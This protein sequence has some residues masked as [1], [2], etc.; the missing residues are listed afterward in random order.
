MAFV[1]ASEDLPVYIQSEYKK[2]KNFGYLM[3]F[4]LTPE[5]SPEYMFY[6]CKFNLWARLLENRVGAHDY[7]LSWSDVGVIGY[8]TLTGDIEHTPEDIIRS[9]GKVSIHTIAQQEGLISAAK[10]QEV[11]IEQKRYDVADLVDRYMMLTGQGG[12]FHQNGLGLLAEVYRISAGNLAKPEVLQIL[13]EYEFKKDILLQE[14]LEYLSKHLNEVFALIVSSNDIIFHPSYGFVQPQEVTDF[15]CKIASFPENV[16]VY[17]PFAGADSYA[18]ALPN[19]VVGEEIN[20]TTWALGQI[21]LFAN[22]ADKRAVITLG[23]S[24]ESIRSNEKFKAI[25]TSPVY[26]M[27]DGHEISDI[28]RMLY[29]K[30]EYGGKLVCIVSANFLFRKDN[31]VRAVRESLIRDKAISAIVML[32]SNIFSGSSIAQAAIV[33]TKGIENKEIHFGDASGH[34][35]FAKSVYRATTFD[36][37]SFMDAFEADIEDTQEGFEPCEDQTGIAVPYEKL[38]GS[39]LTPS[40]YLAPKPE[41]GIPLS[42]LVEKLPE[43]RCKD[44][45]VEYFLTGSSIP[46]AMHRK[47]FVP[48]KAENEKFSTV[49]KYVQVPENAVILAI[50]SGNVRTV[51]TE[52]FT[53][54]IA[55]PDGFINV[56]KPIN[57]ISA[58]YLAAILSTRI[59]ADQIKAQTVGLT[60]PY[61]N[62]LD[63]SQVLVPVHDT[64]EEREK[65]IAEVLS[66]EMSD[67]EGELQEMIDSQKREVRSTRHA[68]VQT[69]SSLS[70]NWEQLKLFANKKGGKIS[71]TDTIG[72]VNPISVE[73][74]LTS[75]GYAIS[76]LERQ[77][78]SLRFERADWGEDVEINP[79][80]FI[81]EYISTH[82]TPNVKMVNV[83]SDNSADIP[84]LNEVTGEVTYYHI[85]SMNFFY[86]PKRLLERIFNN[87][88]AN[89]KAHGFTPESEYP[90][91]RFDWQEINGDIVITI[92]NNGLPLKEGVTSDDVLMSGFSTSLNESASDGTLHSGQ[93]GFEIKSLMNG[94]G[95]VEVIAESDAEF[96][97]IYKLTFTNT[98]TVEIL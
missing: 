17:N 3:A 27:E 20:R 45:S 55:F 59:V 29:G 92:A 36:L 57:G 90:E 16:I 89:A 83:G 6:A 37:E 24:F 10:E 52:G 93:G 58:K 9:L 53:G 73:N 2:D 11:V 87:I 69:L 91:I 26:L 5:V 51:Y 14:E 98:N 44:I 79:Y 70:S 23:D 8:D 33:L 60:I 74:L 76:T 4:T 38:V 65:F 49:K 31:K 28:V 82:S 18:I 77:V 85:D 97:V 71:F 7:C 86:A 46:A 12:I 78:E 94:L 41:N 15:M 39:E 34:T 61:L 30:L 75:I 22:F 42:D 48:I 43:L 68:M 66:S 63:L 62:K 67:L 32:P 40:L 50:V 56:L 21:R 80:R 72:R 96:P 95:S 19:H 84:D 81:N 35:R 25:I 47:P 64:V 88:V 1:L 54:K 13:S